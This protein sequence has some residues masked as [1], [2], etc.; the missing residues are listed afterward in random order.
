MAKLKLTESV[1]KAIKR[2][3][4]LEADSLEEEELIEKL[5]TSKKFSVTL[6]ENG[7]YKVKQVLLG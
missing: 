5:R 7:T 4:N 6:K 2:E 3:L 1:K